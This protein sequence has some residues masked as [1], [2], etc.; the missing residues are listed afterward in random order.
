MAWQRRMGGVAGPLSA[1]GETSNGNPV[2]VELLVDGEWIDMAAAG[3]VLV[4][5]NSGDIKISYGTQGTEGGQSERGSAALQL[6]NTDGRFSPRNPSGAYYGKIGRNTPIRI[7]VPDGLGGKSYRLWGEVAE[8]AP[9]WDTSGTDVWTDITAVGILQRLGQGPA[10]DR[11]TI[12]DAIT[13]PTT[14]ALVA[15]W[16]MEDPVDSTE[17]ASAMLNGS[18]MTWT[19]TP[20]LAA[21]E[22]FGASDPL[23]TITGSALYGGVTKYDVTS[24]TQYQ[25]R[26]LLAVPASG[27]SNLDVIF[28]LQ[29]AEVA[30]GASFLDYFDVHYNAP[31]G[32]VGSYGGTGTLTLL[33]R[34]GDEANF[35]STPSTTMDVRGRQLRVSLENSISGTTI[36]STLRL[37]DINTGET[38][39]AQLTVTSTSLSRVVSMELGPTT[40]AD[41]AGVAYAA[42]GH[43]SLQN[44]ITPIT[45]ISRAIQPNGE[46][47]GRRIQ[48]ICAEEGIPFDWVGDLD[49]TVALGPQPRLNPISVIQEAVLADGGFLYE[50][51][52][53]LGLG[54]RTRASLHNQDPAL[55]LSY[56][57]FHLA[58][59]PV[60]LE[61]DRFIQ[62]KIT[63]TV[64]GV[65]ATY[66]E[67]EGT[68]STAIPPSGVGIYGTDLELNLATS[69]RNTLLDHAAWR[70][71]LGTVDEARFPQISVNLAHPSITPDMRRAI[72]GLRIGDRIQVQNPPSWLPPDT[73]DQMILGL[74]ESITH[75]EHRLTF[76]CSPASPYS[77][78]GF[79]DNTASRIDTDGS[80]VVV[81]ATSSA[82]SLVVAPKAGKTTL[83]TTSAS[84]FPFDVRVGGEVVRVTNV[85]DWMSD[86]FTRT[87]SN[88]WG[89]ADTGQVWSTGGG[90][91]ADYAVASN[92]G[93]HTLA[94]TNTSRRSF[95][96]A[97]FT[98]LDYYGDVL[99]SATA[100]GGSLYGGLSG[101]Y[102]DSS[103]FYTAR[104]EFTTGNALILT[105]RRFLGSVE[106]QLSTFSLPDT[107]TPGTSWV[108]IRFQIVGAVL[109][110]RAWLATGIEPGDWQVSAIDSSLSTSAFLGTRSISSSANTNV[111]PVVSYDN[112]RLINPQTFTVTRSIN[113]VVKAQTVSTDVRLAVPSYLDL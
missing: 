40:L 48:R 60:P 43:L 11:S 28:R 69:A 75:F 83:W 77:S 112:L 42:V 47:A 94:T 73:I 15:Y 16:P 101:R 103:N 78:I 97:T 111:N 27:F 58:E 95:T 44:A 102:L 55:V 35:G 88:G 24:V 8:W 89:T 68:L 62:N 72:L 13:A 36:T 110:A 100:T 51:K 74:E 31:P 23:P 80:E 50:N 90:T 17:F 105:I 10:S 71:H 84:E 2:S 21:Y 85:S 54:Y 14:T 26:F 45:D 25:A 65:S 52:K 41:S 56:T 12:Y 7:S 49:T 64:N 93:T 1:S 34:D 70:V 3:Y 57:S 61:D 79:V 66:E 18:P 19:G 20:T 33:L 32:G 53:V 22:G 6:R 39:T 38:D 67:T 87:V 76:L 108:R 59:I 81:A 82:T 46:A 30:A 86:T 29:V 99:T 63:I 107:Y 91:S 106:T 4:R 96:D 104:V 9:G 109:R 113:N 92:V 98:D 37:L 5:D